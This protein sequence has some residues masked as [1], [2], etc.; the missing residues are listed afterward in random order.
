[1]SEQDLIILAQEVALRTKVP[2]DSLLVPIQRNGI[3]YENRNIDGWVLKAFWE[4]DYDYDSKK[5]EM[6]LYTLKRSGDLVVIEVTYRIDHGM[7]WMEIAS[8]SETVS[9]LSNYT[10]HKMTYTQPGSSGSFSSLVRSHY[11]AFALDYSWSGGSGYRNTNRKGSNDDYFISN[12]PNYIDSPNSYNSARKGVGEDG[13]GLCT[14]LY[15]LLDTK[16]RETEELNKRCRQ[17]QDKLR[18][19]SQTRPQPLAWTPSRPSTNVQAGSTSTGTPATRRPVT[20]SPVEQHPPQDKLKGDWEL[21]GE[22]VVIPFLAWLFI[23]IILK[24]PHESMLPSF[25]ALGIIPIF[26][27]VFWM[28]VCRHAG[29]TVVASIFLI[30]VVGVPFVALIDK[31][32]QETVKYVTQHGVTTV[33]AITLGIIIAVKRNKKYK[34]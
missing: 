19:R 30:I 25:C 7:Q 11:S 12:F 21:A 5:V 10:E 20:P 9:Y 4:E 32:D 18:G 22:W 3:D 31:Q 14:L 27:C 6:Y 13:K 26:C 16:P 1:M 24:K 34:E 28:I 17:E 33:I 15:S 2:T 29:F 8:G 23:S